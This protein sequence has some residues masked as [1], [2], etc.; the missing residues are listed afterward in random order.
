MMDTGTYQC[1]AANQ[2]GMARKT[3]HVIIM[4]RMINNPVTRV[5]IRVFVNNQ[6]H[7]NDISDN[8]YFL[9]HK[10]QPFIHLR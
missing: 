2:Y 7:K 9:F 6:Q 4:V 5:F 3:Y 8:D 1:R 10:S